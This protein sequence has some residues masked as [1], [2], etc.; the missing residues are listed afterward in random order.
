MKDK[1][2]FTLPEALT[3]ITIIGI[4]ITLTVSIAVRMLDQTKRKISE[5]DR[6]SLIESAKVYAE[7]LDKG[8]KTY[9]LT[10]DITVSGTTYTSNTEVKGYTFK[11]IINVKKNISV[12]TSY[13]YEQKYLGD[14]YSKCTNGTCTLKP[15]YQNCSIDLEFE[16]SIQDGYVV[17][18]TINAKLGNEC[19]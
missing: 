15:E 8:D 17:I 1:N 2:G 12:S 11:K 7:D 16:T 13:L 9:K 5:M 14:D 6:K 18:D 3:V 4:I 19:K 10:E